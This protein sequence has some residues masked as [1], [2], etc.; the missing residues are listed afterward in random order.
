MLPPTVTILFGQFVKSPS[1]RERHNLRDHQIFE[2]MAITALDNFEIKE[3]K[4]FQH[5]ASS[6][7]SGQFFKKIH[8][9]KF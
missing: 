1:A 7:F 9:K 6:S 4:M 8:L 5:C 3:Y 2:I